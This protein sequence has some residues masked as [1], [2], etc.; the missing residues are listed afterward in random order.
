VV[1]SGAELFRERRLAE[2]VA[3]L[4]GAV[5]AAG[6][7]TIAFVPENVRGFFHNVGCWAAALGA[8]R[9][10]LL[11]TPKRNNPEVSGRVRWGWMCVGARALHR[12]R[13]FSALPRLQ[14]SAVRPLCA[15]CQKALILTFVAWLVS[16]AA[17]LHL[18][19]RRPVRRA[20]EALRAEPEL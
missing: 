4:G 16:Y 6:L 19:T 1:L 18:K 2:A 13:G 9:C 3:A 20:T 12:V 10:L 15:T 7:L 17:M 5:N 8:A 11:L 14:A